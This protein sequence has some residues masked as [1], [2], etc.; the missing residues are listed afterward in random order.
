MSYI[1]AL[2]RKGSIKVARFRVNW[3]VEGHEMPHR[4]MEWREKEPGMCISH[5]GKAC[6]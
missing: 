1:K 6:H 2:G 3:S 5:D 4:A